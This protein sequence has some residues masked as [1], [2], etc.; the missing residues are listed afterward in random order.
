MLYENSVSFI[1]LNVIA[2]THLL[3]NL[4]NLNYFLDT[5]TSEGSLFS[6]AFTVIHLPFG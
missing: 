1:I 2:G 4:S 5:L 3:A 6:K